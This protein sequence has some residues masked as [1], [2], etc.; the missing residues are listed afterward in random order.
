[1]II[2]IRQTSI[3]TTMLRVKKDLSDITLIRINDFIF[4][5]ASRENQSNPLLAGKLLRRN[6][7]T[8]T[9]TI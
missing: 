7:L 1:M 8:M 9:N 5:I 2:T 3:D 4:F 6:A